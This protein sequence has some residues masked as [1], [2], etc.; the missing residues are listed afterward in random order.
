MPFLLTKKW[1]ETRNLQKQKEK[2]TL[3]SKSSGSPILRSSTNFRRW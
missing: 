1:M 2:P 3:P